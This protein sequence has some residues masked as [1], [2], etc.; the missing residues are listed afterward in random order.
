MSL[1]E[2][3]GVGIERI[4]VGCYGITKG[5][6]IGYKQSHNDEGG[7]SQRNHEVREYILNSAVSRDIGRRFR[8]MLHKPQGFGCVRLGHH[9]S[10]SAAGA[11]VLDPSRVLV[12]GYADAEIEGAAA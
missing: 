8:G 12:T 5:E 10:V 1:Y 3:V 4:Q 9:R 6:Q 11:A 2:M 7:D